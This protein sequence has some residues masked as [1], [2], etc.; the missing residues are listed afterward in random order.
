MREELAISKL[1]GFILAHAFTIEG[2]NI[3]FPKLRT[4]M[5]PGDLIITKIGL[6]SL[7]P[8]KFVAA[9]RKLYYAD[10]SCFIS[11]FKIF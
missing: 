7:L 11:P 6:A 9:N 4:V 10:A 3:R 8:I 5:G 2:E 1:E